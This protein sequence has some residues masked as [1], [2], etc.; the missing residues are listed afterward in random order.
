[1]VFF[2][3]PSFT[4]DKPLLIW[5]IPN[6]PISDDAI[7]SFGSW[8]KVNF[9]TSTY[10]GPQRVGFYFYWT[11]PYN[12]IALI[13]AAT[14]FSA[15]GYV[16]ANAPWS[17]WSHYCLGSANALFNI[18]L[19]WPTS[20]TSSSS[21]S[22]ELGS[23]NAFSTLLGGETNGKAISAGVSLSPA[24]P[25][26]VPP[27]GVVFFEVAL[28]LTWLIDGGDFQADF[29]SGDFQIDCPVV[30]L[31]LVNTPGFIFGTQVIKQTE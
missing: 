27:G 12:D 19:G 1:M 13:N 16:Q 14:S 26:A 18:W 8:A 23:A 17:I 11:N 6:T 15:S 5:G 28:E 7:V 30:V 22:S 31:W 10:E 29:Q 4:L 20:E 9:K 25:F 3:H 2:P 21:D 24:T